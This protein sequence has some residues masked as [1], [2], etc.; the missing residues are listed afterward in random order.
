MQETRFNPKVRM[1]PWRSK[2]QPTPTPWTEEPGRLQSMGLQG[3]GHDWVT[4]INCIFLFT[5]LKCSS[6]Q[7]SHSVVSNS[8]QPHGLQHARILYPSPTPR[9]YSNSC[10]SSR[11]C[12][13]AISSSVIPFSSRLQSFPA[14]GSFQR[15]QFFAQSIGVSASTSVLSMNLQDWSPLGQ[16]G[17]ISLQSKGLT[18]KS[19]RQRHSSKASILWRSAFFR[20]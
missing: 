5:T 16:T 15:S 7:F 18:L 6:V 1:I 4:L 2:W 12:H 9:A 14:S 17:W 20:V 3:A 13:P 8:L 10:P 11:W 19:L